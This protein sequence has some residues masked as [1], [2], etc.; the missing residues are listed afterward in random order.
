LHHSI[1]KNYD[2]ETLL[3]GVKRTKIIELI[4]ETLPLKASSFEFPES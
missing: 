4:D 3:G 1:F 2:L